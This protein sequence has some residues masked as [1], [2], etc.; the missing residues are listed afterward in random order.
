VT[1]QEIAP[2]LRAVRMSTAESPTITVSE[3]GTG[4]FGHEALEP[5]WMRLLLFEAVAAV[6]AEEPVLDR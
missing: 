1:P 6:N 3:A 5:H 4:S 2:A